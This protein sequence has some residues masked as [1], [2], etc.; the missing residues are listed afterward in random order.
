M[1][2]H[3]GPTDGIASNPVNDPPISP[4]NVGPTA[5]RKRNQRHGHDSSLLMAKPSA[6]ASLMLRYKH[7]SR[8]GDP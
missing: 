4:A 8:R 3:S 2:R 6:K 5:V 7:S 1:L